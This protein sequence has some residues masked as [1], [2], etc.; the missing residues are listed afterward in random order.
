MCNDDTERV[1][2]V[3]DCCRRALTEDV[4]ITDGFVIAGLEGFQVSRCA[5]RAVRIVPEEVCVHEMIG[6]DFR[7]IRWD[8]DGLVEGPAEDS[9]GLV[10]DVW[11]EPSFPDEDDHLFASQGKSGRIRRKRHRLESI[12]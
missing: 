9:Q 5:D 8:A 3:N 1:L 7:L 6:H 12:D 11:H 2:G 4:E 10:L